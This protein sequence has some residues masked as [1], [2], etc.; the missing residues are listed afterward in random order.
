M[1]L[2]SKMMYYVD[3][4]AKV[5]SVVLFRRCVEKQHNLTLKALILF[6]IKTVRKNINKKY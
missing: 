2:H 6:K 3:V 4:L 5:S 1:Q